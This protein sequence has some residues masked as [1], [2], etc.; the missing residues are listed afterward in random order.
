MKKISLFTLI[1]L[2]IVNVSV[3]QTTTVYKYNDFTKNDGTIQSSVGA[4]ENHTITLFY[5]AD[6]KL[7][8]I[9]DAA[10]YRTDTYV[11]DKT[12]EKDRMYDV[13]AYG[14]SKKYPNMIYEFTHKTKGIFKEQFTIT[15]KDKGGYVLDD[16]SK[17]KVEILTNK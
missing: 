9:T 14:H 7:I 8:K 5:D 4:E 3:C 2:F 10:S 17:K 16:G 6:G 11:I 1:L 13:H 12:E 15:V